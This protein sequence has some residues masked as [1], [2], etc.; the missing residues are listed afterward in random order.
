MTT[1][2]SQVEPGQKWR[3]WVFDDVYQETMV[4]RSVQGGVASCYSTE[5]GN[6]CAVSVTRLLNHGVYLGDSGA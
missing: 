1:T 5:D 3:L 2:P 4:V 6:P